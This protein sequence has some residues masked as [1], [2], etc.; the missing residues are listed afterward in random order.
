MAQKLSGGCACGAIRYEVGAA[1]VL[2]LNCH[3]RDCQRASGSG[4][5][6]VV[7]VP[8]DAIKLSG[9]PRYH[10]SVGNAGH[11][12]QR[13]FC[14]A[15]GN[16]VTVKLERMPHIF[17]LH[18]ASLDDPST[19]KPAMELFAA[20]ALPWAPLHPDSKKLPQGMTD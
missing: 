18:A 1:P 15:C 6:A 14:A 7:A 10:R 19:Y 8:A 2:M 12:V 9:E 13:G 16:P 20:T 3:C 4:F 11:A 17:G 5:A